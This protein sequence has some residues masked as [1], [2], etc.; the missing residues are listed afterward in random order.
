MIHQMAF[1]PPIIQEVVLKESIVT[2][3]EDG[4]GFLVKG[5]FILT[6]AH[7]IDYQDFESTALGDHYWASVTT[8]NGA[9]AFRDSA[10]K[11]RHT[12]QSDGPESYG[13]VELWVDLC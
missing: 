11:A 9:N 4:Q 2:V 3:N 1:V 13:I 10:K 8:K 7:C 6:A 12:V 5:G